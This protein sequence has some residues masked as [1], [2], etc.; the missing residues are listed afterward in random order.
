MRRHWTRR[1]VGETRSGGSSSSRRTRDAREAARAVRVERADMCAASTL[2]TRSALSAAKARSNIPASTPPRQRV[3]GNARTSARREQLPKSLRCRMLSQA[4]CLSRMGQS[5]P[6]PESCYIAVTARRARTCAGHVAAAAAAL[7]AVD[8][9]E[10]PRYR[11][12]LRDAVA[13][14]T[15]ARRRL[16]RRAHA[17]RRA[18]RPL[19]RGAARLLALRAHEHV[20][21]RRPEAFTSPCTLASASAGSGRP[22][23][24]GQ[25]RPA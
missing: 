17:G 6:T 3:G 22:P 23:S 15:A 10:P 7:H 8:D 13:A 18:A 12:A 25:P 20:E 21:H 5:L 24:L 4:S 19:L 2:P 1:S 9:A 14:H 16:L 11:A